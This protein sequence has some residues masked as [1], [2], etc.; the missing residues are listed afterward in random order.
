MLK[1]GVIGIG[2]MG[3]IQ[4]R[5]IPSSRMWSW[6]G[7]GA[8]GG[9]ASPR[10]HGCSSRVVIRSGRRRWSQRLLRGASV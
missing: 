4:V 9:T 3:K 2:S 8:P 1:V 5:C 10:I 7:G 6:W